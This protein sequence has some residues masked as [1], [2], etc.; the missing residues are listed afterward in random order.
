MGDPS[1]AIRLNAFLR[2]F[3]IDFGPADIDDDPEKGQ[4][5]MGAGKTTPPEAERDE[6][7]HAGGAYAMCVFYLTVC[8]DID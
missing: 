4:N 3:V 8:T 7:D 6:D 2:D 5:A 1:D